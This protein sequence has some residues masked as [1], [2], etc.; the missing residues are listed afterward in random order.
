MTVVIAADFA[1]VNGGAAQVALGSARGLAARGHEVIL[2][3]AVGPPSDDAGAPNVRVLCLGQPDVWH[4]PNKVR[5]A[6]RSLWNRQAARKMAALLRGLSP[7]TTIVHLHSWTK[8]L[9]S[10]VVRAAERLGFSVVLTLHDY[11]AVCPNGTFFQY[12]AGHSCPLRP[13]SMACLRT[14]CDTHSYAHK[15]VRV[16]RQVVQR[17]LGHLT[18]PGGDFVTVSTG[19]EA[20]FRKFLP[21]NARFHRVRNFTTAPHDPPVPVQRNGAAVYVGR[22]SVEKG[23]E[24]LAESAHRLGVLPIFIG[25]GD[26]RGEVERLCP[27]AE[28]TGW[29]SPASVREHLRRARVLVFPSLW[30]ETQGLVVAEAAA[31]GVPALVPDTSVTREWV[32]DGVTGLWFK[33]GS[34]DDLSDKLRAVMADPE[35]A[36]RLG[37]A[38]Y[39]AFWTS[40]PTLER[41]T[42]RLE[43]VYESILARRDAR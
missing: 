42:E 12:G 21:P 37:R 18:Q 23:P 43:T 30:S 14:N 15:L 11:L 17:R 7:A 4:D 13:L 1:Y 6:A 27:E 41:H 25:D 26:R 24:L 3:T 29:V 36:A 38:A 20:V 2:F 32:T 33:G 5:A 22:L 19:S 31:M 10:S 35:L 9:S 40:P 16:G 34:V 8:A 39:D 28:I